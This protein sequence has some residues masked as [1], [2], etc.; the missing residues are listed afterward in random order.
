M[1]LQFLIASRQLGKRTGGV[2]VV[3]PIT[4]PQRPK[5]MVWLV[6]P[7]AAVGAAMPAVMPDHFSVAGIG[8]DRRN[9]FSATGGVPFKTTTRELKSIASL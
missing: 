2:E 8:T 6:P 5:R 4:R 9:S 3:P 7:F 1:V